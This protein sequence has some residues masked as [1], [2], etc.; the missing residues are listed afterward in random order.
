MFHYREVDMLP[1]KWGI[2]HTDARA[3]HLLKELRLAGFVIIP[4][5]QLGEA[6]GVERHAVIAG[7][8]NP[9]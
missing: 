4:V 2:E 9:D 8:V 6:G 3:R 7:E 1:R 5:G